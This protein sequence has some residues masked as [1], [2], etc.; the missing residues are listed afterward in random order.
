MDLVETI[1]G[2]KKDVT[3]AKI[4]TGHYDDFVITGFTVYQGDIKFDVMEK[5]KDSEKS[6][7]HLCTVMFVTSSDESGDSA[8]LS[9]H[10]LMTCDPRVNMKVL[11]AL[12]QAAQRS[13]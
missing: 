10:L 9:A 7:K 8:V 3:I 13:I 11:S 2:Y 6:G 12:S 5:A 1:F 4:L